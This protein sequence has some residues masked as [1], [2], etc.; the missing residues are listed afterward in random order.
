MKCKHRSAGKSGFVA[1]LKGWAIKCVWPATG[2]IALV[3]FLI[4][5]IPK[6][7]R[8][9]YPCQRAAFPIASSFVIYVMGL[10]G[11]AVAFG[12]ARKWIRQARYL[13]ATICVGV[14]L[15]AMFFTISYN[16]E[17]V[18]GDFIP[19]DPVNSPIGEAKGTYPGRVVWV[20]DPNATSWD[21]VDG[22][23]WEGANTD[24]EAVDSM[25]S[26]TLRWLTGQTNDAS[27]WDTLFRYSNQK[28]GKDDVGY[29]AGERVVVKINMNNRSR[30]NMIDA[31]PHLVR[32]LL[33]QLVY[34]AGV[35]ES[36]ITVYDAIRPIGEPVY[37]WC[38]AEFPEVNYN[39]N[40]GWV[41]DAI[42]YS[43]EI[44]DA[45]ASKLPQCV[46]DAKYMINL[47]IL[48]RHNL[49]TA[50]TLC[51]KNHFG[52]IGNPH[53]LHPHVRSWE[54]G[55]GS[56]DPQVDLMGHEH[57]GGKTILYMIDG[58]YGS[59]EWNGVPTKWNS[60]PFNGYWPASLLAS[61][62]PVAIDSVGLDFLNA[63]WVLKDNADNY[64]HEASLAHDPPSDVLYDPEGDG[65]RLESLGVHEHWN[66]PIDKQYSRNLG[67]GEGIEL[68]SSDPSEFDGKIKGDVTGDCKVDLRDFA[69]MAAV[70]Q[71]TPSAPNWNVACDLA[72]PGGD[73]M[74]G[75]EDLALLLEQWLFSGQDEA[76]NV[77]LNI[78]N[79]W[80][81]QSLPGQTNSNLMASV[82]TTD[83]MGNSSY[84]YE[85]EIILPDD[86]TTAPSTVSGG[87][88]YDTWTFAAP[89][90]NDPYGISDSGQALTVRVTVTGDDC[91]NTGTAQ[92]QF[93]IALLGD[94]NNSGSI[95]AADR[96][97][98]NGFF[99]DGSAG[100]YSLRDCDLN[101]SGSVTAADRAI[102]NAAF[103]GEFE[104]SGGVSQPC[105]LR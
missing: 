7:S 21:G 16:S 55:M 30:Y 34:Q 53:A 37:N 31:S 25:F 96:A 60:A 70:W 52:S 82:S 47:A 61:Q 77:T 74:I 80:M 64:L 85:W 12:K 18:K 65:S 76:L 3:W 42:A 13:L 59:D 67:L 45:D 72:P 17:T 39:T 87:D 68:V 9:S 95:T 8:A 90:C 22:N 62:D 66:N 100:Q 20:H 26:K 102:V 73:G 32:S 29:Q 6:P 75:P 63:E 93:G 27:A 84:T 38:A 69:A 10:L 97:I 44:T 99:V 43:A 35:S 91:G 88:L 104:P 40:I 48:K 51:G 101:C 19:A 103:Y 81:Y 92:A 46:L 57:L 14:G 36:A 1:R 83:P 56:Y 71:A 105:P 89:S 4:R 5:V 33:R 58:L 28:E 11:A 50:V 41:S 15:A 86:V 54:D 2:L 23:W 94:A 78:D 49:R 98:V 24:Q 79:S